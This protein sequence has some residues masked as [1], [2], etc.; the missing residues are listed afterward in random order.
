MSMLVSMILTL[1]QGRSGSAK[2]TNQ[3]CMLSASK[4]AICIKLPTKVGHFLRDLDLA[5][6]N[7]A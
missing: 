4:Q 3:D 6:D 2:A 5:N 7:M 1:M